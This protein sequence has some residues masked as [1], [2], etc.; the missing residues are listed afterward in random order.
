MIIIIII[1]IVIVIIAIFIVF[2]VFCSCYWVPGIRFLLTGLDMLLSPHS[3]LKHWPGRGY[4][5]ID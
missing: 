5:Q 2:F 4:I 1:I 3:L